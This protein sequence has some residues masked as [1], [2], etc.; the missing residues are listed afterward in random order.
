MPGSLWFDGKESTKPT[1]C[2]TT[3]VCKRMDT[4]VSQL[5]KLARCCN[6]DLATGG[7]VFLSEGEFLQ[8]KNKVASVNKCSIR[9]DY[10]AL[11]GKGRLVILIATPMFSPAFTETTICFS[12]L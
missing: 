12:V 8:L 9:R 7:K 2:A 4:P 10:T 5:S 1:C 11:M 6:G 3:V